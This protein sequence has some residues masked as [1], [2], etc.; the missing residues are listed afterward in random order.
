MPERLQKVLA[1]AG[2]GSRRACEEMILQGEVL[3]DG[4]LVTQ[5]GTRVDPARQQIRC[6]GRP[7]RLPPPVTVA[8]NKPRK[9]ISSTRDDRGRRT[10]L[11]L[12]RT[13]ER[14]YPVGRLDHDSE[15][16]LLLTNDGELCHLLTH[17]RY[18]VEK[19]YH[20]LLRGDLSPQVKEKIERGVWLSEGK[21]AP[22]R[23]RIEKR[24]SGKTVLEISIR[25]GMNR[26]VRRIFA[27]FGRKVL[28]LTRVGI[29]PLSLGGLPKGRWRLLRR[30]E[31]EA[32]R[33]AALA[34]RGLPRSIG[35]ED[36]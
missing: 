31:V 12:V 35:G 21:T 24:L 19:R 11:D 29:G 25:E 17:P 4:R 33:R 22:C 13:R 18:R 20:V 14:L 27:K 34:Q 7:V 30:E 15:G 23:I 16:L 1:R 9:V 10:V 26:E 32:L 36:E 5:P 6:Q 8:L 28:R 3:V 2:F